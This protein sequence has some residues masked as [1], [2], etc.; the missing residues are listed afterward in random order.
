MTRAEFKATAI[1]RNG[2]AKMLADPILINAM[3]AVENE[4]PLKR[5]ADPTLTAERLLGRAEG[6]DDYATRLKSLCD[7]PKQ[8]NVD[9][10]EV[11]ETEE[12]E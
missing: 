10:P 3:E 6:Y 11:V 12:E 1:F 7:T 4:R 5:K 2:L 9:N 8:A